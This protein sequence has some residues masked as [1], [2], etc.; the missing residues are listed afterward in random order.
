MI[1]AAIYSILNT[2]AAVNALTGGRITLSVIPQAQLVPCIYIGT[3]SVKPVPVRHA[4]NCFS[5]QLE[6]GFQTDNYADLES[7]T[8]AI[9]SAIEDYNGVAASTSLRVGRSQST[10]DD[11][12]E[13]RK[14]HTRALTFSV[15]GQLTI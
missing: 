8:A 5:G 1:G 11:Y 9:K 15:S 2:N 6:V 13:E 10:P 4:F 12:D 3:D 14:F 7:L